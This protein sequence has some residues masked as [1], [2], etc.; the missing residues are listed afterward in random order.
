[1]IRNLIFAVLT[2]AGITC[3]AQSTATNGPVALLS[4]SGAGED[5]VDFGRP[6]CNGEP[7]ILWRVAA[8]PAATSVRVTVATSSGIEE[9]QHGLCDVERKTFTLRQVLYL[10]PNEQKD[11]TIDGT[12][13]TLRLDN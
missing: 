4:I 6:L 12:T 5:I 2:T 3:Y 11:L 10:T 1:M 7:E 8:H 13:V 9:T